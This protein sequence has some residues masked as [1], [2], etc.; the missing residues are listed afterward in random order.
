[1][2]DHLVVVAA[3]AV[4]LPLVV[5]ES[6]VDGDEPAGG[7]DL[8]GGL[9]GLAEARDVDVAGLASARHVIDGEAE[10]AHGP[11]AGELAELGVAG[12]SACA[13]VALHFSVLLVRGSGW[14][15]R[16]EDAPA[17]AAERNRSS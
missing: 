1:M 13:G 2:A 14:L 5:F 6:A 3:L 17:K 15:T 11:A 8:G 16:A 7:E 10:L 4:L 12:Q 9:A